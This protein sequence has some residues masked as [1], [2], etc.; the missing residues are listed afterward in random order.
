MLSSQ[1]LTRLVI[2]LT[3]SILL[4]YL[5]VSSGHGVQDFVQYWAGAKVLHSGG[6]PYDATQLFAIERT[7]APGMSEPILLW[8]PPVIIPFIAWLAALPFFF[9][10]VAWAIIN[11][12]CVAY[13]VRLSSEALGVRWSDLKRR[14]ALVLTVVTFPAVTQALA[15]GQCSPI[16]V[17]G[18]VL[19][20][21]LLARSLPCATG[22]A[23]SVTVLKPH[24]LYLWWVEL[25]LGPT[26]KRRG[27]ILFGVAL[28]L[29][30]LSSMAWVVQPNIF[31]WYSAAA[32]QPP[33]YWQTPTLGSW[34]ER[35]FGQSTLLRFLP[36][37]FSAAGYLGFRW[38]TRQQVAAPHF[39]ELATLSILTSP[40]G[41]IYD[42]LLALPLALLL[43]QR[44]FDQKSTSTFLALLAANVTLLALPA[45]MGQHA[46]VWYP[47]VLLLLARLTAPSATESGT[48]K[49][50]DL[51]ERCIG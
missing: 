22:L 6:N 14:I 10:A 31:A 39:V 29:G 25:L 12:A 50:E 51:A 45:S 47:I 23:L 19:V 26:T 43:T 24:L 36:S 44:A 46:G 27:W 40:Y 35:F 48:P 11:I 33:I 1:R 9:A 16:I 42:Q 3:G 15:F 13:A 20:L 18:A 8:N 5:V 4:G 2:S 37:L 34:L 7:V 28:G 17:I 41:W 38:G 30:L 49:H 32:S 21:V